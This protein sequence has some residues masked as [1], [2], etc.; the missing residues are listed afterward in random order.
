MSVTK[1]SAQQN[2]DQVVWT[3]DITNPSTNTC[4]DTRVVFTV[5]NGVSLTGPSDPGFVEINVPQGSF[6]RITNTWWIGEL[7]PGAA[8]QLLLEITVDDIALADPL[9]GYFIVTG[10]LTS[11]CNESSTTDN[12]IELIIAIG[13]LCDDDV[14]S[15]GSGEESNIDISIG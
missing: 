4:R 2:G 11:L 13:A 10:D 6:D 1:K 12:K 3:I 5:P 9:N 15:I 14:L 7:L 8:L